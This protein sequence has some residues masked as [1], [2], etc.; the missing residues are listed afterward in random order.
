MEAKISRII[1]RIMS[2]AIIKMVDILHLMCRSLGSP[3]SSFI[4]H[5]RLLEKVSKMCGSPRR[6]LFN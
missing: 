3:T 4:E 5:K 2:S 6:V 1:K